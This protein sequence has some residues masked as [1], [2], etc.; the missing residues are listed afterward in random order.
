MDLSRFTS[1]RLFQGSPYRSHKHTTY[2]PVYDQLFGP[3][4]DRP[5]TFVEIGVL[6]GGS[7]F[8]WREFFGK[9]ARI[10]GVELDPGAKRWEEHGFEIHIGSQSDPEFWRRFCAE[11]G[12]IDLLLDD[13]GHTYEQQIVTFECLLPQIRDGGLAVFEDTHSSYLREFGAP[14]RASFVNYA[15]NIVDGINYRYSELADAPHET[16]VWSIR[17]LES[18]VVFEVDRALCAIRSEPIHN[19]G[20]TVG[21]EDYRYADTPLIVALGRAARTC[22][23]LRH[24]PFARRGYHAMRDLLQ[25]LRNGARNRRLRRRFPYPRNHT[26]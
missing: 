11:V 1:F 10:I 3:Y 26:R 15:R 9:R 25:K 20:Q 2:F 24:V 8:M 21:A 5:I 18:F 12:P 6:N 23:A 13:G 14:S 4:R 7:L 17:F 22:G 19:H 16:Q